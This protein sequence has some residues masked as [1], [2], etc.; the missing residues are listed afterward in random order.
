M[1]EASRRRIPAR[2]GIAALN[3]LAP[4]LGL[5]RVQRLRAAIL[6]LLAPAAIMATVILFYGVAPRLGFR[7]W[8]GLVVLCLAA[9][10]VVYIAA[11]SMSWRAS[12]GEVV[13]GPWWSRWYG[14]LAAL[15]AIT[16]VNW[17][18]P[19][20]ARG[21]YRSFYLPAEGMAPT[22]MLG[23]KFIADMHRPAQLHRGD[24]VLVN[25]RNGSIYVKRV[26]GLPGDRIAVQDGIVF[27]EG[28]PVPQRLIGEERV[29][30]SMGEGSARRLAEQFP[31][32]A[33][34]HEIYDSGP[35]PGDDFAEQRVAPGHLFL[36]GD[37]R[38][39]SADSRFSRAEWGLEQV[40]TADVRGVPLFFYWT[41]GSHRIG[42]SI[43]R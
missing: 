42:D 10:L 19:D 15:V 26:A 22:L 12:R 43:G 2:L 18:L 20:V 28:R 34:P 40:P 1:S 5:L 31:G 6:F 41:A 32:E 37:N 38:D 17:P 35:S 27:L 29:A 3:L 14:I 33:S 25:A 30:G 39:H 23:D 11:I 16:A 9:V 13:P 7:L 36:L 4:G 8:L 21:H 24:I